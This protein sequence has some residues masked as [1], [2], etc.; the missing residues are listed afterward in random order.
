MSSVL[1]QNNLS[2]EEA[3]NAKMQGRIKRSRSPERIKVKVH[4]FRPKSSEEQKK[5]HVLRC[6]IFRPRSSE[7]QKK[8]KSHHVQARGN[9]PVCPFRPCPNVLLFGIMNSENMSNHS[10]TKNFRKFWFKLRP[11][12]AMTFFCS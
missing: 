9:C 4:S 2:S 7:D 10:Y 12:D 11:A 6:P 1:T 3:R 8:K 5:S